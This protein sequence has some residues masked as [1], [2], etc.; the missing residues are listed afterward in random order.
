MPPR[1]CVKL[2]S[3]NPLRKDAASRASAAVRYSAGRHTTLDCP[4]LEVAEPVPATHLDAVDWHC[5]PTRKYYQ[6]DP[7]MSTVNLLTTKDFVSTR[8][9]TDEPLSVPQIRFGV[10]TGTCRVDTRT[11]GVR[12]L[13]V[14]CLRHPG[15]RPGEEAVRWNEG[16]RRD[17]EG[18]NGGGRSAQ[19]GSG[20]RVSAEFYGL[21]RPS[22]PT[23]CGALERRGAA[24][25]P[26]SARR[27]RRADSVLL[28]CLLSG[29][30]R[31]ERPRDGPRCRSR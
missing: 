20:V 17:T 9:S 24:R 2:R 27:G 10:D 11:G 6:I 30:G 18:E 12:H 22:G 21:W 13:F 4:G 3:G 15:L 28:T 5:Q 26:A 16:P 7:R 23:S 8:V 31:C 1:P 19:S 25:C 14:A 29:W